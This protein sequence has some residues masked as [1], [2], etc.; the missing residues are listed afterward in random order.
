MGQEIYRFPTVCRG[1]DMEIWEL[2]RHLQ[3]YF[4]RSSVIFYSRENGEKAMH[5]GKDG[6]ESIFSFTG[7]SLDGP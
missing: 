2:A 3:F 1:D 7:E 4:F 5:N 6:G